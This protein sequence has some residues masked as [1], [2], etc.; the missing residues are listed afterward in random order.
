MITKLLIVADDFTGALDTGIQ[1]A[2]QGVSTRVFLDAKAWE[3][4][5]E[6]VVINTSSRHL[7]PGEAKKTVFETVKKAKDEGVAY[8]YKKTDSALR[9]N[10]AAEF[11]GML[12]A[13]RAA[14]ICFVP[15][16]PALG[17]LTKNGVHYVDGVKVSESVYGSDPFEPVRE[18]DISKLIQTRKNLSAAIKPPATMPGGQERVL[19]YDCQTEQDLEQTAKLFKQSGETV[20]AGCAG[21]AA[22]I[23]S[24]V[25]FGI[26]KTCFPKL[27]EGLLVASAS[28]N[29][30]AITQLNYAE[31][32]G[33][34]AVTLTAEQKTAENPGSISGFSEL[35]SSIKSDFAASG[36]ILIRS[37][38]H[39]ESF[40]HPVGID[41]DLLRSRIADNM[42]AL[43]AVL[44]KEIDTNFL[45]IGGDLL[46]STLS[47]LN[48]NSVVPA[49]ESSPGVVAFEAEISGKK[50]TIFSKSG[51]FGKMGEI[52]K[53]EQ[54]I[55]EVNNGPE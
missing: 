35:V 48:V 31:T 54:Y 20:F 10:I 23:G 3:L 34:S 21:F 27:Q 28:V 38:S 2:K 55:M 47:R 1:L 5:E 43:I 52:I 32:A 6:A 7:S 17:R 51:G 39:T 30:V 37:V 18:S 12:E 14:R 26:K 9:G 4:Q 33:F 25:D 8:F 13:C 42:G 36:R 16:Y 11:E 24:I 50:R 29:P 46:S 41:A 15:A 22:Y 19:V 44:I 49:A 45:I 53:T 40:I